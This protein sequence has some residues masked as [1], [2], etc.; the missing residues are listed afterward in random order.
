MNDI[1]QALQKAGVKLP[2]QNQ[3]IW[4]YLKDFGP[5]TVRDIAGET[6]IAE[7][8][9]QAAITVMVK[10]KMLEKIERHNHMGVR[11]HNHYG[12]LGKQFER[13][14][15]P[16]KRDDAADANKERKAISTNRH[17]TQH[18]N[19]TLRVT[20]ETFKVYEQHAKEYGVT[21]S[22]VVRLALESYAAKM[23]LSLPT[24]DPLA[25]LRAKL[26]GGTQ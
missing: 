22:D 9:V 12:A 3:R 24:L 14:P 19:L 15:A 4:T 20:M 5:H 17:G 2:S 10:R 11:I 18:T 25:E 13:L 21:L 6:K 16:V 23:D 7:A 26:E 8:T 1:T